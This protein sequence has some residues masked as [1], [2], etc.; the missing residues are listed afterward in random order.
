MARALLLLTLLLGLPWPA[1]GA[2]WGAI[3]PGVSTLEQ[4]R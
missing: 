3:Q 2:E 1:R 4:V